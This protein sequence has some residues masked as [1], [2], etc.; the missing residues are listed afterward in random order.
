MPEA[1]QLPALFRES[2]K[3]QEDIT[4]ALG[5]QVRQ[6]VEL[7][8]AAFARS[9]G[10]PAE[11]AAAEVYRGAVA[12]MMRLVFLLF[13][14]ESGLLPVTTS[15]TRRPTRPAACTPNS[16]PASRTPGTRPSSTTRYLAWHRLLAL[17]TG[18]VHRGV[19]APGAARGWSG[20]TGRCSTREAPWFPLTVDDRTVLHMLGPSRRSRSPGSGERSPFRTLTVEQIGYVYEGLLSFEGF[21]AAEVVVGLIGKEGREE[22]VP[23]TPSRRLGHADL[24]G[25]LAETATRTP[26]SVRSAR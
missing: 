4:E 17:S 23:L 24:P 2:L 19:I 14:E 26:A 20:V 11:T 22:E 16:R 25:K 10:V 15:S 21:R 12:V 13:A 5:V 3:H 9:E 6:A 8:V 1:R 7:L 18:A